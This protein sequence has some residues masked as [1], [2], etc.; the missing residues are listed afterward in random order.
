MN[1]TLKNAV[2][3]GAGGLGREVRDAIEDAA[4]TG[5]PA[6][7]GF[8]DDAATGPDV[9]GPVSLASTLPADTGFIVAIGDPG[10]RRQLVL[11]LGSLDRWITVIHPTA[12]VSKRATVG[13]GC[14]LAPLSY[15]GAGA[16]LGDHVVVNVHSQVGHD[17]TAGT[18]STLSPMCALNG[19][20][21]LGEGCF[22]GTSAS[23][24]VGV[25][26]GQWT[27]VAAGARVTKSVGDGFLLTGNPA[28]GRAM[29]RRPE[30]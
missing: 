23:V 1:P 22:L 26:I 13:A 17:A 16:V 19:H 27:K 15:V 6:F 8:L 11:G 4:E 14:F 10:V 29:F 18:F 7:A 5:G 25:E 24:G 3:I 30:A 12:V 21:I 28:A 20:S 9:L 2:V